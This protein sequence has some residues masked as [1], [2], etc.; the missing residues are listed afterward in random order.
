MVIRNNDHPRVRQQQSCENRPRDA[1]ALLDVLV[2][3]VLMGVALVTIV[4]L[5]GRALAAQRDG[6]ALMQAAMLA[7][8]L[9]SEVLAVGPEVFLDEYPQDGRAPAP[10]ENLSYVIEFEEG[11]L[12]RPYTVT[13][14]V[15]TDRENDAPIRVGTQ[16]APRLGDEPDPDR[17]PEEAIDR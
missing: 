2:A 3:G 4:G 1:F 5:G 9:L 13:V 15:R 7:D 14:E 17:R 12:S 11:G 6:E 16:I 10:Y 8:E